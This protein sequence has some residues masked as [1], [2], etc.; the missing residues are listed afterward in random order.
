MYINVILSI[1]ILSNNNTSL[2][3]NSNDYGADSWKFK[4]ETLN[5]RSQR[6]Y[7]N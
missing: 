3:I 7:K 5:S 1:M 4:F 2:N 6:I